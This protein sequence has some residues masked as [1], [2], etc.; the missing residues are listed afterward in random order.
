MKSIPRTCNLSDEKLGEYFSINEK[1]KINDTWEAINDYYKSYWKDEHGHHK[2]TFY[3]DEA[4]SAR[5]E[6]HK[7]ISK[8]NELINYLSNM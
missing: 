5:T 7:P 3:G 1:K 2:E 4:D 6:T 8:V